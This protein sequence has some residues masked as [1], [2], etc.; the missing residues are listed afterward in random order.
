MVASPQAKVVRYLLDA[1]ISDEYL[2]AIAQLHCQAL[3]YGF[4]SRVGERFL[5]L[6]YSTIRDIPDATL[7]AAVKG[8]RVVGFVSGAVCTGR[9]YR[10]FLRRHLVR[11]GLMLLPHMISPARLCRLLET[12]TYPFRR[13]DPVDQEEP[14][15]AAELLSIAVAEDQRGTGVAAELYG[16]LCQEFGRRRVGAFRIVVGAGLAPARRFYAKMGAREVK[17]I[18]VHRGE[19]SVVLVHD[20]TC[21]DRR[22]ET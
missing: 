5:A 12:L 9:L 4:L 21:G 10:I 18:A 8:D 1:E 22:G 2:A 13:R 15:P 6:L 7:I 14:L 19:E 17:A 20:M 16:L 3:R 11:G